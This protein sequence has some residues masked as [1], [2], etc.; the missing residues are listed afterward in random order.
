MQSGL[1]GDVRESFLKYFQRPFSI[2][3]S[4]TQKPIHVLL[5][6]HESVRSSREGNAARTRKIAFG[7]PRAFDSTVSTVLLVDGITADIALRMRSEE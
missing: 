2:A 6:R 5:H 7:I 4:S 3:F 1:N